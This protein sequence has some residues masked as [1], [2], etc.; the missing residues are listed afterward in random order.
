MSSIGYG[1][2]NECGAIKP[3]Y[4]CFHCEE[5]EGQEL[6]WECLQEH[7]RDYHRISQ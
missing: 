1:M 6:C 4:N 2:C 3:L 5:D 7:K